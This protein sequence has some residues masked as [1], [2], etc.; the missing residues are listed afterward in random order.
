VFHVGK[1]CG[2]TVVLLSVF[3][4]GLLSARAGMFVSASECSFGRSLVANSQTSVYRSFCPGFPPPP[5][6]ARVP[7]SLHTSSVEGRLG[8]KGETEIRGKRK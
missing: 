7:I 5:S 4:M 8:H 3:C 6:R 1:V 2:K